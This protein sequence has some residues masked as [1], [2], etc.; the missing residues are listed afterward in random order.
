[1]AMG[2]DDFPLTTKALL[3]PCVSQETEEFDEGAVN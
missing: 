1:M 3:S 2:E